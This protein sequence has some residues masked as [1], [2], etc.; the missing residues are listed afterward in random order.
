MK[1]RKQTNRIIFHHSLSEDVSAQTIKQWHVAENNWEDIGYHYV[2]RKDGSIE[3]GRDVDNVGAHAGKERNRESIGVCFTGNF[4]EHLPSDEQINSGVDL[5]KALCKK[6]NKNLIIE[7]HRTSENPCPGLKF[8]RSTFERLCHG[9]PLQAKTEEKVIPQ[10]EIVVPVD[11][12][13]T[14][15]PEDVAEPLPPE[16]LP[17]PGPEPVIT[18]T[19]TV[20]PRPHL[21]VKKFPEIIKFPR[22]SKWKLVHDNIKVGDIFGTV[23][24]TPL[25][26][27]IKIRTWGWEHAFSLAHCNHVAV[28][29]KVKGKFFL[30][31]ALNDGIRLSST[32]GYLN[33]NKSNFHQ[34]VCWIGRHDYMTDEHRQFLN[35]QFI[36]LA[37]DYPKY[38]IKGI[39]GFL[40]PFKKP[41]NLPDFLTG[42]PKRFFCN[43]M[44]DSIFKYCDP[45]L[46]VTPHSAAR[47]GSPATFQQSDRITDITNTVLVRRFGMP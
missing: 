5:Y 25:A 14:D 4:T 26:I 45:A 8:D 40:N 17:E 24:N 41:D 21:I 27:G 9:E 42:K 47:F 2:I 44:I 30:C 28:V 34:Q 6:Y 36:Q 11:I 20:A 13:A 3:D 18:E 29:V 19:K 33:P 23:S 39:A 31:E 37:R 32:Y 46:D 7:Y 15:K 12:E 22:P 1:K 16:P 38:N 35:E 43:E 10:P